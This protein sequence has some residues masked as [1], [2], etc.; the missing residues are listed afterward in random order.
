MV[1][2]E[3]PKSDYILLGGYAVD[4]PHDFGNAND[5]P[6][7]CDSAQMGLGNVNQC[8]SLGVKCEFEKHMIRVTTN[9]MNSTV[10]YRFINTGFSN[11]AT[12][13]GQTGEFSQSGNSAD[14]IDADGDIYI[15]YS[16][17]N[18]T[19]GAVNLIY[20]VLLKVIK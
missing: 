15:N 7:F 19:S 9:T 12:S 3:S 16:T 2:S 20:G 10:R 18:P 8:Y 14:I 6:F 17:S 13:S 1:S 11:I 5:V 4:L